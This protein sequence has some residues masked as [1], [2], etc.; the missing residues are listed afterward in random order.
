MMGGVTVERLM[1]PVHVRAHHLTLGTTRF[2]CLTCAW[3]VLV[4]LDP[5]ATL[6]YMH[7]LHSFYEPQRHQ[8]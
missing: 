4:S 3:M 2:V 8:Q 5:S 7:A 1:V 6:P